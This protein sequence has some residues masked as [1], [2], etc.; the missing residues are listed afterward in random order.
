MMSLLCLNFPQRWA[1]PTPKP[2]FTPHQ[3]A[4]AVTKGGGTPGESVV[5]L[6]D[7]KPGLNVGHEGWIC[8][9]LLHLL[10]CLPPATPPLGESPHDH[11]HFTCSLAVTIVT[12]AIAT[13]SQEL[14]VF[15]LPLSV[16]KQNKLHSVGDRST[17][18][19][20][21]RLRF[22]RHFFSTWTRA[23]RQLLRLS[24][25]ITLFSVA[26]RI[27]HSAELTPDFIPHYSHNEEFHV[28]HTSPTHTHTHA[29]LLML[30]FFFFWAAWVNKSSCFTLCQVLWVYV[31][32]LQAN[33]QT[34]TACSL[35]I[36][37]LNNH[38]QLLPALAHT[39]KR[40]LEA[41]CVLF[42]AWT[43]L[44]TNYFHSQSTDFFLI[45]TPVNCH[46]KDI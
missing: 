10:W 5:R 32:V 31:C 12:A 28:K 18:G 14:G 30:D 15:L 21:D 4:Q 35:F 29:H 36:P 24:V 16:I 38:I 43:T 1:N 19:A 40:S 26:V 7:R 8:P 20:L 17:F 41:I 6:Y 25:A 23:A 13:V 44:P 27:L 37:S 2:G 3:A 45:A 46:E 39:H 9:S 42:G 33:Q 22:I 11:H 34:G